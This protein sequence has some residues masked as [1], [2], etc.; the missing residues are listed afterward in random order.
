MALKVCRSR[1]VVRDSTC[2]AVA[3]NRVVRVGFR[4]LKRWRKNLLRAAATLVA[5]MVLLGLVGYWLFRSEPSWYRAVAL[6]EAEQIAGQNRLIDRLATLRNEVGRSEVA[7]KEKRQADHDL[8]EVEFTEAEVNG[9]LARWSDAMPELRAVLQYLSEPHIRFLDGRIELAGRSQELGSLLS[10]EIVLNETADGPKVTLGRPF[11]GKFPLSRSLLE[12][13]AD[14]AFASL[15]RGEPVRLPEAVLDSL[16]RFVA[17]KPEQLIV[18]LYSS[19]N[20]IVPARVEKLSIEEGTLKATLR[21]LKS[22]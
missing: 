19:L 20:S 4:V 10:I 6:T 5:L 12:S 16:Q 21:P 11:A 15:R 18:P 14:D 3:N 9:F 13:P 22:P 2:R 8:I 17:G 7:V 1:Q